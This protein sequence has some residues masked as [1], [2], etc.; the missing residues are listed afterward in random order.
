MRNSINIINNDQL[1]TLLKEMPEA[2]TNELVS[3]I[4]KE[5]H[6]QFN[7]EISITDD[8]MAVEIWG[9]VFAGRFADAIKAITPGSLADSLAEKISQHCEVINIGE[10]GHDNNRILWDLLAPFKP[11][12]SLLLPAII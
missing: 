12:I 6:I 2:A 3:A 10:K 8:S 11:A 4:K 9:H 5:F 1:S 7:K